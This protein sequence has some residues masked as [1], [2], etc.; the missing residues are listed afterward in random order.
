LPEGEVVTGP[1][2]LRAGL[3]LLGVVGLVLLLVRLQELVIVFVIAVV[4]AEG[5]RPLVGELTRRG[6]H[7]E[8][9]RASVYVTL[10]AA[11]VVVGIVLTRPVVAQSRAVLADLPGY[12]QRLQSN[13]AP[14][15][16]ALSIDASVGSQLS[17]YLGSVARAGL[18]FVTGVVRGLF[19][20]VVVL[21]LS[22]LWLSAGARFGRFALGLLPPE[23][24]P[25]LEQ[26]WREIAAGFAGYV[27]G[28]AVNMVVIGV[29]TGVA[30]ALLDL[31]API[32][33]G[34][35][36]GLTEMIPIAGPIIGAIPAILLGFTISPIYPLVVA[37]VYLAIQQIEAHTLVPAV[38]RQAV[39]LPALVVVV[40][41]AAGAGLAGVG[42]ALVAVPIA[43]SVQVMI[44]RIVGPA[45]R[46]R[47]G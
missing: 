8:L 32:L 2:L 33:L 38:M 7:F 35:F 15:L 26:T 17:G 25:V 31:P 22:F 46:E 36:A 40:S 29:L 9:A 4:L 16:D 21:L 47:Y 5:L 11:L 45:I 42:G 12:E 3:I 1:S 27:R 34:V 18:T 43:F 20:T 10:I 23:R 24:R 39:G 41:I 44:L 28:V 6:L 37:V 14:V 13:L 19:D 30:A